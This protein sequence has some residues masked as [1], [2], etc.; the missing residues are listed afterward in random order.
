MKI[1]LAALTLLLS[2]AVCAQT[3]PSKKRGR[4][5]SKNLPPVVNLRL[6]VNTVAL[7]CPWDHYSMSGCN[8]SADHGVLINTD[9]NDSD[10]DQLSYRY[11]VT[12]GSVIG[13]GSRVR[14]DLKKAAPGDYKIRVFVDDRHGHKRS[15][16]ASVKVEACPACDPP[17]ST[18]DIVG[19]KDSVEEGQPAIFVANFSGGEEPPTSY[20][21]TISA[22]KIIKGQGTASITVDTTGAGGKDLAV[23]VNL[24]GI[25]PTCSHLA[26]SQVK[27]RSK[28]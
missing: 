21:W 4:R 10:G 16:F 13:D 19:P 3:L 12:G 8:Q 27:I 6:D 15:A 11:V 22:G 17:C 18:L 24:A 2:V 5:T 20:T 1:L 23:I 9:A 26:S 7:A 25:D 28:D 14:W